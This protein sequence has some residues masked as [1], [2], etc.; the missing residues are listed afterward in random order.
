M[1]NEGVE[2][3]QKKIKAE[4]LFLKIFNNRCVIIRRAAYPE[5]QHDEQKHHP[6]LKNHF[7]V[8]E[9]MQKND[10]NPDVIYPTDPSQF[11]SMAPYHVYGMEWNRIVGRDIERLLSPTK[12]ISMLLRALSKCLLRTD[13]H[14]ISATSLGIF[15]YSSV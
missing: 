4:F 7:S 8:N 14:G 9:S 6:C 10:T 15:T 5:H 12:R 1:E 2:F 13:R 3:F 11:A